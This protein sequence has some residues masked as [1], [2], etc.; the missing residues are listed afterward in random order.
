MTVTLSTKQLE[1]LISNAVK[2]AL[3][4]QVEQEKI[5]VPLMSGEEV[6]PEGSVALPLSLPA[7]SEQGVEPE[8]QGV[9]SDREEVNVN[10]GDAQADIP[11]GEVGDASLGVAQADIDVDVE[12]DVSLGDADPDIPVG[13]VGDASLGVATVS[14]QEV[15]RAKRSA[16]NLNS[17]ELPPAKKNKL[18]GVVT[19]MVTPM[20]SDVRREEN[21]QIDIFNDSIDELFSS[22]YR[23]DEDMSD[24]PEQDVPVQPFPTSEQDAPDFLPMDLS[25]ILNA[26]TAEI[27]STP[28]QLPRYSPI[29]PVFP[30]PE[31]PQSS[32]SV[33]RRLFPSPTLSTSYESESVASLGDPQPDIDVGEVADTTLGGAQADINESESVASLADAQSDIDVGEVAVT[34]L[35]DVRTDI[36][37]DEEVNGVV[38]VECDFDQKEDSE[39]NDNFYEELFDLDSNDKMSNKDHETIRKSLKTQTFLSKADRLPSE[40]FAPFMREFSSEMFFLQKATNEA[41]REIYKNHN[42]LFQATVRSAFSKW[43]GMN[44]LT[45]SERK[46]PN[47]IQVGNK[48]FAEKILGS[49]KLLGGNK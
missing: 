6:E 41:I 9:I 18:I 3:S 27:V 34:T 31:R 1:A 7:V 10:L 20:Q 25:Q 38:N 4:A 45:P 37:V 14:E 33:S 44:F 47:H 21:N 24:N 40:R 36:N 29:T 49:T 35:G 15:E 28:V 30:Q 13:E 11:V 2:A 22:P 17:V 46:K 19:P 42:M 43:T 32:S 16:L 23:M 12:G 48:N 8:V 39:T 5:D 26:A